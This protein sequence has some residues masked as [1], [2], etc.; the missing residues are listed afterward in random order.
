VYVGNDDANQVSGFAIDPATGVVRPLAR[1][2]FP[3]TGLQP[4]LV[5]GGR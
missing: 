4:E 3:V 5:V 1:S 2:P